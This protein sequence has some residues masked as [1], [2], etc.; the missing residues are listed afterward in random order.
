[1]AHEY[2]PCLDCDNY[3]AQDEPQLCRHGWYQTPHCSR[4][5]DP[6]DSDTHTVESR[7]L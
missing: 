6:M 1:M 4:C 5:A 3:G 2:E 7:S